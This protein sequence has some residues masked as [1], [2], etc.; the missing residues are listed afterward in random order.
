[1]KWAIPKRLYNIHI[2]TLDIN[3]INRKIYFSNGFMGEVLDILPFKYE[4]GMVRFVIRNDNT[5]LWLF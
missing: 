5:C 2:Y 4:F 3:N 1:M